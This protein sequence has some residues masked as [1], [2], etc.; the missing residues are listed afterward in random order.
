MQSAAFWLYPDEREISWLW[1]C[2]KHLKH[3]IYRFLSGCFFL[4]WVFILPWVFFYCLFV[5]QIKKNNFFCRL[6]SR[7]TFSSTICKIGQIIFWH[8]KDVITFLITKVSS[9]GLIQDERGTLR[10]TFLTE[11]N[12]EEIFFKSPREIFHREQRAPTVNILFQ[13]KQC[14]NLHPWWRE[15]L[16]N[17]DVQYKINQIYVSYLYQGINQIRVTYCS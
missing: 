15:L 12:L 4:P 13:L 16:H 10:Q 11:A 6:L 8:H 2:G 7:Q 14:F 3:V 9:A 17:R 1:L 5:L